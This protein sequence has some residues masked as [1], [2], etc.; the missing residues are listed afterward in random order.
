MTRRRSLPAAAALAA[1]LA[2]GLSACGGDSTGATAGGTA[3]SGSAQATGA[4]SGGDTVTAIP[5]LSGV[6]TSVI[7][8]KSTV[9]ALTSLKVSLAPFGNAAF[10]AGTGTITF[11]ITSGYAEI[12]SDHS[13]KPG[14]VQGSIEHEG[15]G[16]T[17]S[18]GGKKVTLSEFV[19]DPGNSMLYGSVTGLGNGTKVNV[20]LLSLD[21]TDLKITMESGNVVLFGTVAKLTDTAASALNTAFG[22]TAIKPGTPLGV[23]RLVAN[24]SNAVTFP[25]DDTA[26]ST[27]SRLA[28]VN[29]NVMLDPNTVAAVT[30][31]GVQVAP[32][33]SAKVEGGVASFPITGG[34]V[35]IHKSTNFKPGYIA[36]V[37]IHEGSGLRFSAGGGKS[38]E[39]RDFVVDPGNSIL[40]ASVGNK[41]GVPLLELDGTNVKVSM[42]GGNVV[43]QGTVAK[44]TPT[45]AQALNTT[46]GTTAIQPGTPLGVVRLVAM[47]GS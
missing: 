8:D 26:G 37:V 38:L 35:N 23:V 32:L 2:L 12:H 20:P 3:P 28:G 18:G 33:G 21:G 40:T 14:F 19:V 6:G 13:V 43:L 39:V 34:F 24:A 45:A 9:A 41:V 31:L 29:T 44:L 42:E 1:A 5:A 47:P 15:S 36:G 27:L 11:P 16:F 17:L 10:D 7:L 30:K 4:T 22:T 46:F 25:G